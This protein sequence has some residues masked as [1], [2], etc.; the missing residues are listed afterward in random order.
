MI[1]DFQLI[2]GSETVKV[3]F[4]YLDWPFW[5]IA[6]T[7]AII[8]IINPVKAASNFANIRRIKYLLLIIQNQTVQNAD[9]AVEHPICVVLFR[10]DGSLGQGRR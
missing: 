3:R 6:K 2:A 1:H 10:P 5:I 8:K 7:A 4:S 9:G